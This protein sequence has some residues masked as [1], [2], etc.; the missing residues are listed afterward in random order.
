M[1]WSYINN[2][3]TT[4]NCF[5][6]SEEN[7]MMPGKAHQISKQVNTIIP[8]LSVFMQNILVQKKVFLINYKN[9]K[10]FN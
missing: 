4:G 7:Q 2:K 8:P 9:L 6:L 10:S 3:H 1:F 5:F